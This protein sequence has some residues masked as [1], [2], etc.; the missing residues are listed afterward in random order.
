MGVCLAACGPTSGPRLYATSDR[1]PS[2][3]AARIENLEHM[4]P[5]LVDQGI[6]FAVYSERAERIELALFDD[7]D[8]DRPT[9]QF[10]MKRFGDVWN[11]YV[12]GVGLG[13]HYGFIAWGPNWPYDPAFVPGSIIGFKADVDAQGNRFNPNKLVFDPYGKALHR[14]HDWSKGSLATG[15]SRTESTYAAASKSVV[16][17]SKYTWTENET[18][19]RTKR[20]REDTPGHRWNDMIMYELHPKGF[21]ASPSSGVATP[22]TYRGLA[23]KADYLKDLGITAIHVMPPFE[24]P[25]EGGYWGYATL[26]F[27]VPENS[28]AAKRRY[29]EIIDE[30]KLMVDALHQ[31]DIEVCLDVVYNHTGEGGFWR[32]RLVDVNPDQR[33]VDQLVNFDPREVVGLYSFRGL[34]NVAYYGLSAD[35]QEYWNN[36]GVGNQTRPNHRPFRRLIIDSLRYWVEEMHV[37]GFRFDLAPVLGERDDE[38][39]VWENPK[40]TVL[41]DIA[42]DP[43]LQKYNTRLISEPWAAGGYD[44]SKSFNGPV[45]NGNG[46]PFDNGYGTRIGL[47]PNATSKPGTGWAEWNGR[48]RDWWRGFWNNDGFKLNSREVRDGGFFLTASSDWFSWNGRKPY[49]TMNF[50]TVHDGFTMYDLLSYDQKRNKCGP[51]NPICCT[52]PTSSWCE[53]E[54]GENNNRSRNWGGDEAMKRQIMRNFFVSLMLS[55]GTPLMYMGD[56][57]LRTQLGNNN[58][59]GTRADNEYNWMDW[60]LYESKDERH[61]MR[62]FVRRIIQFRK[63]HQY[64]VAP[65]EYGQGAPFAWKSPQNTDSV[66]W[67]SK[68]LMM[69]YYDATKGPELALLINGETFDVPFSVPAGRMW[70]RVV[71]TQA[72]WDL[73]ETL[74]T[75][76][77]PA[78]ASNNIWLE[79]GELVSGVYTVKPRSIVVLEAK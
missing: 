18:A 26:S 65:M 39:Y 63:S 67:G 4:G 15:P 6:N 69:H 11:L 51:L 29:E 20:Q 79:Q 8:S 58:A 21:T 48:F 54:S 41:Q 64:A 14:D 44:L 71:D 55:Q 60:G 10:P 7:P 73:P 32:T 78:R 19:Y 72:Y 17:Q 77:L 31:R 56:E 76:A 46:N 57:W 28:Y 74:T 33:T 66:D 22:G 3:E 49:H 70:R 34:D 30:F 61:R 1:A 42:D 23:E 12:E 5:T 9:R 68:Q 36:A 53:V 47:F 75:Q 50:I 27:F 37:D 25:V 2:L 38:Y 13:Q 40:N 24:K 52:E 35:R 16:V 59:Y 43:V 62:D 45:I